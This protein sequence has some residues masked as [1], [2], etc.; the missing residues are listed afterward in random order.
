M[1]IGIIDEP[2]SRGG[3]D[4]LDIS[5]HSNSLIKFIQ[6]SNT[7]ITIGIQGEWGSG[8]TSLLNSI[9]HSFDSD[10]ECKQ[11]WVNA[12]EHSLLSTP[13][14]SLLKIINKIIEELLDADIDIN[15][16]EK[17]LGTTKKIFQ[18]ALRV[19]ASVALGSEASKVT[20]ELMGTS[21]QSIA[22]LRK[23]LN[24]LVEDVAIRETNP[25]Q[26]VI[27]YVDDLDRIEPKNA[28][29]ILELLKN[30]FNLPKC[31]FILAI[32]YQVV[33]KGLE[34]KFGK[35]TA[36]N[37]W[38][39]RAFFDKIIQ[40]P[41]MMP[42]NQYNIGKYVNHLLTEINFVQDGLDEE[43]IKEILNRT[44]GG[45]PRSIKRLINSVSL[46]NVFSEEKDLINNNSITNTNN[47]R[48]LDSE[49]SE[50]EDKFLIFSLLCL[51][52]AYPSIYE[53]LNQY[54]G[55]N[56]WDESTAFQITR[57]KEES[58]INTFTK[59]LEIAEE[60]EEFDEE[61]EKALF[62]ICYM[63]PRLKP[64]VEDISKYFNYIKSKVFLNKEAHIE[65]IISNLLEKTSVTSVTS[66][67]IGQTAQPKKKSMATVGITAVMKVDELKKMF[68]NEFGLMLRVYDGREFADNNKTIKQISTNENFGDINLKKNMKVGTLEKK[69]DKEFGV[70]VQ[71]S[72]SDDSYL[73][74][75]DST[76]AA[77][78]VKDKKLMTKRFNKQEMESNLEEKAIQETLNK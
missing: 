62:R 2:V 57:R 4:N 49:L 11:I 29:S 9:Y 46:I 52:I 27:V 56:E 18:G 71:I 12:W 53:I 13:E 65:N 32:D 39:F 43:S 75:D 36:E 35:Q 23:Q 37:E 6:Q 1:S 76:L 30:I 25:F 45:N 19:G 7:P 28:V 54:P 5:V 61:W 42:M 67:D 3:V 73:C 38:E 63:R 44:I 14:E 41:F 59:E 78:L 10:I 55:F 40:L 70:K 24:G 20:Q 33:V 50:K 15:R 74:N 8:K 69:L 68:L 58:D 64:R 16:K 48:M 22:G 34:H 60:S 51:Q 72:G 31:V 66:T 17:I 26:K 77:S 47:E 21:S